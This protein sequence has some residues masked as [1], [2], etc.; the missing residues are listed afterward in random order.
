MV[1]RNTKLVGSK[2]SLTDQEA[3]IYYRD[4]AKKRNKKLT[5]EKKDYAKIINSIYKKVRRDA[6]EYQGGIYAPSF[7]YISPQPYPKKT[8]MKILQKGGV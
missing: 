4:R 3:F 5:T 2:K 6:I 8:F 7:F 1:F